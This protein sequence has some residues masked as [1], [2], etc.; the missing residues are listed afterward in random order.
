MF[1]EN[2][3]KILQEIALGFSNTQ[4]LAEKI[5]LPVALTAHLLEELSQSGFIKTAR[6]FRSG[7]LEVAGALLDNKGKAAVESPDYFLGKPMTIDKGNT[8]YGDRIAGDKVAGDKVMGNKVQIGTVQGDAIAGNK[9]VNSQNLAQAA[10]EIKTL[11]DQLKSDYPHDDDFTQAGRAVGAI[12]NNPTLKQRLI[13]AAKESGTTTV[14]KA[15]AAVVD[16]PAVSIV[17][18]GVKG[19]I[20]A[21]GSI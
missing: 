11:L 5:G 21:E 12:K 10:Q 9:I 6:A 1:S 19:F 3:H 4:A 2:H 15:I 20:E 17:V 14:E 13:N 16:H 8:W 7:N 18:A